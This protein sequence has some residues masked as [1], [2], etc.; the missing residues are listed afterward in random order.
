MLELIIFA[1]IFVSVFLLYYCISS[2]SKKR[3]NAS[4]LYYPVFY[5]FFS[6]H[7]IFDYFIG[8]PSL[9]V[10]LSSLEY[11]LHDRETNLLY[12]VFLLVTH[13]FFLI[14]FLKRKKYFN[15]ISIDKYT[16]FKS[17]L[18]IVAILGPLSLLTVS[19]V[20]VYLIY[21]D[22][23]NFIGQDLYDEFGLVWLLSFLSSI[24]IVFLRFLEGK[25]IGILKALFLILVL[26]IDV[27]INNKRFIYGFFVV[28][29]SISFFFNKHSFINIIKVI[30][31]VILFF[32]LY[33]NYSFHYKYSYEQTIDDV[34]S[35]TRQELGRDDV[36]KYV[37]YEKVMNSRDILEYP[38]QS[39]LS[40]LLGF[41]PR[42][43]WK[44][45]P[46][47]YGQYLT[48]KVIRDNIGPMLGTWTITTSFIDEFVSN[49]GMW[50]LL[51]SLVF[52]LITFHI[53]D[54]SNDSFIKA[55]VLS[56]IVFYTLTNINWYLILIYLFFVY[57]VVKKIRYWISNYVLS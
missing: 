48:N 6:I 49:F 40:V 28:Y 39:Y 23:R 29:A 25:N 19:D 5:I 13:F 2:L 20:N 21:G 10:S 47:P 32:S 55:F 35:S 41:I 50:G 56:F 38:G 27:Y 45:K 8:I 17:L 53:F 7:L 46:Y 22:I 30:F 44:D 9:K 42:E 12:N 15:S 11:T 33:L 3:Y 52:M 16:K 37:I 24:S 4:I 43:Y 36:L 1:N 31:S 54:N 18:L 51:L 57:L 26:T 34:Y 14:C